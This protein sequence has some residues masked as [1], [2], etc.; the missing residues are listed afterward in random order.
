[1]PAFNLQKNSLFELEWRNPLLKQEGWPCHQNNNRR[2]RPLKGTDG[3]VTLAGPPRLRFYKVASRHFLDA[4]PPLL[5]EEGI[6][7]SSVS[8]REGSENS[9]D[10][11]TGR[12][13]MPFRNCRSPDS[14][15]SKKLLI[16][17]FTASSRTST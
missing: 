9:E 15:P 11:E 14:D 12:T 5:V 1:M 10:R 2:R 4:Q 7:Y 3:V 8:S 16:S 6:T 17:L 13:E